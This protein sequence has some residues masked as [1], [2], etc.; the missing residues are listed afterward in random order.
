MELLHRA[1]LQSGSEAPSIPNMFPSLAA[2]QVS[3][4]RGEVSMIAG[5]P[6]SG[7]ST[8]ALALA[9][10]AQ[11]PTVY[12]SADSHKFTQSMRLIA[13]LTETDQQI[14]ESAMQ[15]DREWASE[16]LQRASHIAW[17][18]TSAPSVQR[19][20]RTCEAHIELHSTPPDFLIIDNLMDVYTEGDEWGG[21]RDFLLDMK[22]VSREY[23]CAVLVLHHA[24]QS[25]FVPQGQVPPSH[26]LAGKV[27]QTPALVLSVATDEAGFMGVSPVKNRYGRSN[28]SGSEPTWFRYAPERMFIG[29]VEEAFNV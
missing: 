5:Q 19:I 7:K 10:R 12:F 28:P 27:A 17:D 16:I 3:I 26:A 4:R 22:A 8:L 29:E 9:V 23:G 1:V 25:H 2:R 6:A 24:T 11:V 21:K 13:M 18:F 20:E 14:V 15:E